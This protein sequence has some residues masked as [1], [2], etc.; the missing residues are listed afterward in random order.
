MQKLYGQ[1]PAVVVRNEYC[2]PC[3]GCQTNCYDFNPTA[4][5]ASDLYDRD[6]WGAGHRRFF[7]G[8]YPGFVIGYFNQPHFG[9]A[10]LVV[11]PLLSLGLFELIHAFTRATAYLLVV[12]WG[13]AAL[14]AYYIYA[15]PVF[16]AGITRVFGLVAP[17]S[18]APV[19]E[20][21]IVLG[22]MAAIS[23]SVRHEDAWRR[24]RAEDEVI[25]IADGGEA[26][27]AQIAGAGM[28]EILERSSGRRMTARTRRDPLGIDRSRRL[29]HRNGLPHGDV[30]RGS[31]ARSRRGGKPRAGHA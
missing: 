10:A 7:A 14:A 19:I 8:V 16:L 3:V 20:S 12:M 22:A 17:A 23:L 9:I 28:P 27:R 11:F 25:K 15:T 5:L 18:T 26:L 30:R 24:A 1:L 6:Q 21:A 13:M 31:R 2:A 4:K 29:T